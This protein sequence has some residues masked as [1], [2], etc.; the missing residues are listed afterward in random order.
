MSTHKDFGSSW[1]SIS[2]DGVHVQYIVLENSIKLNKFEANVQCGQ[3]GGSLPDPNT[4]PELVNLIQMAL[5]KPFH[6]ESVF[7]GYKESDESFAVQNTECEADTP[8]E[9]KIDEAQDSVT[10]NFI[11][12]KKQASELSTLNSRFVRWENF[13]WNNTKEVHNA[14]SFLTLLGVSEPQ[15]DEFELEG[16]AEGSGE[17]PTVDFGESIP[18]SNNGTRSFIQTSKLFAKEL[19]KY[20]LRVFEV[21]MTGH[22][23]ANFDETITIC[24]AA[25]M[26][27][28][29][30]YDQQKPD[31]YDQQFFKFSSLGTVISDPDLLSKCQYQE[32]ILH[33]FDDRILKVQRLEST[34]LVES[35]HSEVCLKM[36]YNLLVSG[37]LNYFLLHSDMKDFIDE[38]TLPCH[39]HRN[40]SFICYQEL[41][42]S[43]FEQKT[44]T[45]YNG[46]A[47]EEKNSFTVGAVPP[48]LHIEVHCSKPTNVKIEYMHDSKHD[49]TRGFEFEC[50]EKQLIKY[51]I[52]RESIN[53]EYNMW[54]GD[55]VNGNYEEGWE[56]LA[57]NK[58]KENFT[59]SFNPGVTMVK[60]TAAF[61][62]CSSDH[63][64][65]MGMSPPSCA[66]LLPIQYLTENDF[67][68][69]YDETFESYGT[70]FS[71]ELIVQ[72]PSLLTSTTPTMTYKLC[73]VQFFN[74]ILRVDV[75]RSQNGTEELFATLES[76]EAIIRHKVES[77]D[78]G[79]Q[80]ARQQQAITIIVTKPIKHEMSTSYLLS[81]WHN[82]F[83]VDSI[84]WKPVIPSKANNIT[85]SIDHGKLAEDT[86]RA[87]VYSH[88]ISI[89][90]EASLPASQPSEMLSLSED[91]SLFFNIGF[92]KTFQ[93]ITTTNQRLLT[94]VS[95]TGEEFRVKVRQGASET[96]VRLELQ[97]F[98]GERALVVIHQVESTLVEFSQTLVDG[99]VWNKV[100]VDG[101][102]ALSEELRAR[103]RPLEVNV[104]INKVLF[105]G[106]VSF[107]A[108]N[109]GTNEMTSIPGDIE[110][111]C[112]TTSTTCALVDGL[113]TCFCLAGFTED[114]NNPL[115]CVDIDECQSLNDCKENSQCINHLNGFTC[116]CNQGFSSVN[117]RLYNCENVDEC[118]D[119]TSCPKTSKCLDSDGSYNCVCFDGYRHELINETH[120]CPD[121]DECSEGTHWCAQVCH[122]TPGSF[123]CECDP[124]YQTPDSGKTCNVIKV[125]LPEMST[126]SAADLDKIAA[127]QEKAQAKA[128][129]VANERMN[130]MLKSIN[131]STIT[132]E[133]ENEVL[134]MT[135]KTVMGV[136]AMA[137]SDDD[138][139]DKDP[140]AKKLE[141]AMSMKMQKA[142]A[143]KQEKLLE[144]ISKTTQFIAE[145]SKT[146]PPGTIIGDET[147]LAAKT[148]ITN[149]T[150]FILPLHNIVFGVPEYRRR[151]SNSPS[152]VAM[153]NNP[154]GFGEASDQPMITVNDANAVDSVNVKIK[155]GLVPE[156]HT[157]EIKSS[158]LQIMKITPK[159]SHELFIWITPANLSQSIEVYYQ[160]GYIPDPDKMTHRG[161][162]ISLPSNTFTNIF[163]VREC[164]DETDCE[165]IDRDDPEGIESGSPFGIR[166]PTKGEI[167]F[168]FHKFG[169]KCKVV[170]ALRL[171][172]IDKDAVSE[173]TV[174][175]VNAGC[176]LLKTGERS[177][178]RQKCS[179][180][181]KT[182]PNATVCD[183]DSTQDDSFSV[184]SDI[185]VPPRR[186]D[187]G[188][189]SST[190][191]SDAASVTIVT[192]CVAL[193]TMYL[194]GS[195][196]AQE[197]INL[198]QGF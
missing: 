167:D 185:F 53:Q 20:E 118:L 151:S 73:S 42:S 97:P 84:S 29:Q 195:F 61:S 5:H 81:V 9:Y 90:S 80:F 57:D 111:H 102:L 159:R 87:K 179:V 184:T 15:I 105:D 142:N 135:T 74:E 36:N 145:I 51:A 109:H 166:I 49:E 153:K 13:N 133:A 152:L 127:E 98:F 128:L 6:T 35:D 47:T 1:K 106:K 126:I 66:E 130:D 10:A 78:L 193:I 55:V 40:S 30:C 188:A 186:L 136:T 150:N 155:S 174:E 161:D 69:S 50:V 115:S 12:I 70:D 56:H 14:G 82:D 4:D 63:A 2:L 134:E 168:C 28:T 103:S 157:K 194:F 160:Y 139:V 27:P 79:N 198:C 83:P 33:T 122:N 23:A 175:T 31:E 95:S 173:V 17:V 88:V 163:S 93:S 156:T 147:L 7:F 187:F 45:L 86:F 125:T 62:G 181:L 138:D 177:W 75:E 32:E 99:T 94:L 119:P 16:S 182:T 129:E 60:L 110:C 34:G 140:T 178:S 72:L 171:N 117:P 3:L 65:A 190:A 96:T 46:T 24:Q 183:C 58:A 113:P 38:N 112:N 164:S 67:S 39:R 149:S 158:S 101:E 191:F 54:N 92:N 21:D 120:F 137:N 19:N 22:L 116:N 8:F 162:K 76:T 44:L 25:F 170:L 52:S 146:K 197:M 154:F 141:Q 64:L 169:D 180:S 91:Y 148:D 71:V 132:E 77:L 43:K 189:I 172:D 107:R 89:D 108:V 26:T 123:M 68:K 124:G 165:K 48:R 59:V 11:C 131:V 104:R 100:F 41:W 192:F 37:D 85:I 114:E 143:E 176:R 144:T 196:Y 18:T 121:I